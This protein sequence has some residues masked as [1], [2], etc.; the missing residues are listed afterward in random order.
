VDLGNNDGCGFAVAQKRWDSEEI[1]GLEAYCAV[2]LEMDE[3][4]TEIKKLMRR[5]KTHHV[6]VDSKGHG[7]TTICRS[8]LN[9]GIPATPAEN[10]HRKLPLI[11]DLKAVLRN[12]KLKLHPI[13]CRDLILQLK[14]MVW[15]EARD[16]HQEGIP[17]EAIDPMLWAVFELRKLALAAKKEKRPKLSAEEFEELQEK[18]ENMRAQRNAERA[19][20]LGNPTHRAKGT[21]KGR[22]VKL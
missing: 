15:N 4:A 7:A 5:Y 12:G 2:N 13:K 11:K 16:S 14:Q 17:D 8:L 10:N 21:P 18:L 19:V 20:R 6:K 1:R 3:I 22:R 9:Y